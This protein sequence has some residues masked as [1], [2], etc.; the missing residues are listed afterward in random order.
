MGK[1]KYNLKY[2]L[3]KIQF[4]FH[5]LRF[6]VMSIEDTLQEIERK[7]SII[8]FGDGEFSLIAGKDILFQNASK[9]L[10]DNLKKCLKEIDN[11]RVLLCL[12]ETLTDLRKFEKR[13]QK[14]W[15]INFADN[16]RYYKQYC[17]PRY[18][19]GN[20]FVSRPYMAYRDKTQA[21]KN[22]EHLM[23]LFEN[24]NIYIIE[25][26]LSRTGVGNNLFEKAKSISRI[27]CP[28][29]NAYEHIERIR[30]I[31]LEKVPKD[32]MVLLALGPTS[33]PLG[34]WLVNHG[35]WVIDIG[36]IDSEYEW[37]LKRTET[38]IYIPLKHT[39]EKSDDNIENCF[40]QSYLDSIITTIE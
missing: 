18:T 28:S 33:K 37:Y 39:A 11:S 30:R 2:A 35:Y 13:V 20:A 31:S 10:S 5:P 40:D 32:A 14:N 4:F 24:E 19:Y 29:K 1:L 22:F 25:G 6:N 23:S 16:Y 3:S 17:Y 38:K 36:H 7:K 34:L 8:R 12:P 26:A 9:E 27:I 21:G 15:I